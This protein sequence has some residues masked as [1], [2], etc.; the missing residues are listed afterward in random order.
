[1]CD[2][3]ALR[4]PTCNGLPVQSHASRHTATPC[5][6]P[7]GCYGSAPPLPHSERSAAQPRNLNPSQQNHFAVAASIGGSTHINRIPARHRGFTN[8]ALCFIINLSTRCIIVWE[9]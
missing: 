4:Q 3:S 1:M 2:T 5:A 7:H 6:P 9:P 8:I